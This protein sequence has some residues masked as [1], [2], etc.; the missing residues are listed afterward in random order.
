MALMSYLIRDRNGTYYFRRIIPQALRPF[1]PG[2]WKG[3]GAW[4]KSLRTKDPA[5]AKKAAVRCLAD[6]VEDFETA[7]RAARGEPPPLRPPHRFAAAMPQ[8]EEIEAE[9]LARLLAEDEAERLDG[10]ARRQLQTAEE[11]AQ[12]PD[13]LEVPAP[14]SGMADDHHH[15]YG[16]EAEELSLE[17]REAQSKGNIQIVDG[18]VRDYLRRKQA[19]IVPNSED[20]RRAALAVLRAHV[21]AYDLILGR[22]R[23]DAVPTP[24][25]PSANRGPKLSDAFEAWKAGSGARGSK[26]PAAKTLLEAGRAVRL[27]TE[28]HGDIRLGDLTREKGR[29]FSLNLARLPTHLPDTLRRLPMRELLRRDLKAYP[30]VHASTV[31]KSLNILSAIVSH[32]DATGKLD[33]VPNFRNP[34]GK[35]V[36]QVVDERAEESR[37]PFT[38]A[39]LTAIFSTGVFR[40]GAR[41]LGGGGEAA[42]WLPL[43]A[44]L[45]GGR[46]GELAQL[47]VADLAQDPESGVWFLDIGVTGGRRVKTASSLRRVPVHPELERIGL[48]RYRQALVDGG[49][50]PGDSL[51]PD[52]KLG[53]TA[54][55][56]GAW[57]KWFTRLLREGAGIED[58]RKVF[59]SF[60]HTFKR[61][62]RDARISEEMHDAL[63]GHTGGGVGR[64]YGSGFGLKVLAQELARIEAPDAVRGL[65]WHVREISRHLP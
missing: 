9:E 17:F 61:L 32:A 42:F 34:F 33:A 51:W 36:K 5:A 57:S 6:C 65:R 41:P 58:R 10:D 13:L 25:P 53:R 27:L 59:H 46:Q 30:T 28:W 21:R 12:W 44:L 11:R 43:M 47:R 49:A 54:Q 2:D 14:D 15:A 48:L 39:D 35:G 64:E 63:T 19:P 37:E 55:P 40:A 7:E 29:E 16:L 45:S 38:K 23:G 8:P 1:M 22:Q 26:K 56:A 31:N 62:A 52:L 18:A 4:T 3:K 60:R 20:Y 50:T 24:P